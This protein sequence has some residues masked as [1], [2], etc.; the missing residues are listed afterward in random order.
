[1][2]IFYIKLTI[3]VFYS[4]GGKDTKQLLIDKK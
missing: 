1:L 3:L 2:F 4:I